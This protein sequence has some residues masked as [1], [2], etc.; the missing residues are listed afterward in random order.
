M[1]STEYFTFPDYSND[2]FGSEIVFS[3]CKEEFHDAQ[4]KLSSVSPLRY[5]NNPEHFQFL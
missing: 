2:I 1:E 4:Q 3:N 5:R